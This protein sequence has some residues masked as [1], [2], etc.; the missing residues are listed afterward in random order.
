MSQVRKNTMEVFHT[1]T[2]QAV[3]LSAGLPPMLSAFRTINLS[4]LCSSPTLFFPLF[5]CSGHCCN[6][7]CQQMVKGEKKLMAK[8]NSQLITTTLVF[9][10]DRTKMK[11]TDTDSTKPSNTSSAR[12]FIDLRAGPQRRADNLASKYPVPDQQQENN[13][14][15]KKKQIQGDEFVPNVCHR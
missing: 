13:S 7:R 12:A 10:K 8:K 9:L 3:V 6:S 15:V 11:W 5:C 1:W 2:P 4:L 14:L